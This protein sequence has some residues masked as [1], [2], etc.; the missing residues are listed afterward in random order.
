MTDFSKTKSLLT[1]KD[2]IA[3][4]LDLKNSCHKVSTL[5]KREK[6]LLLVGGDSSEREISL[7]SGKCVQKAL[8][9]LSYKVIL[10]D[11]KA[12][13]NE[14]LAVILNQKPDCVFNALHGGFGENGCIQAFLNM[15][16]IPYTHSGVLSSALAMNK[17]ETKRIAESLNVDVPQGALVSKAFLNQ[18]EKVDFDCVI[19]PNQEGSSVGVYI[20]NQGEKIPDIIKN[21]TEDKSLLIEEYIP[22]REFSVAV[23]DEGALGI[24]E[25]VPTNGFYDYEHKYSKGLTEHVVPLDLLED[26]KNKMMQNA[27]LMHKALG[28]KGV[29]RS[30]FRYDPQQNRVVFLELNAN[31]GMTN[32]SLVPEM[33]LQKGISYNN[34]VN[35][36]VEKADFER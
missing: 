5:A 32:L 17:D 28:C 6:I 24:I 34:L 10:F 13:L 33:A 16:Q 36:L 2:L 4:G 15:L 26:V 11:T 22:G 7:E 18:K 25:L 8:E 12:G 19:K 29:S 31:P 1:K 35:M 9:E 3:K 14:L 20:L 23:V 30:D 21:E 27:Y